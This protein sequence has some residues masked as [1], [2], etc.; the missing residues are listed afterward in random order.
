MP[1]TTASFQFICGDDDFLVTRRGREVF[2]ALAGACDDAFGP[3]II[4]GS[5]GNVSEV[6]A[7]VNQFRASAETLPLFGGAKIIW[8]RGFNAL[9]DSVTGRSDAAKVQVERLQACLEPIDPESVSVVITAF[10]VDRR[11]KEFKWFQKNGQVIDLK[12]RDALESVAPELDRLARDAG[13]TFEPGVQEDLVGQVG[14]NARLAVAETEKLIT[15]LGEGGGTIE[16]Q[17]LVEL[18]PSFGEGDFFETAEAF[19]AAD[20]SWTL[21]ALRRH[22]FVQKDARGLIST[23]Q[24]R[25]RILIQLQALIDSGELKLG[26]RG[27]GKGA[28]EDAGQRWTH[29][30]GDDPPKSS[31]NVFSQNAWYVGNRLAPALRHFN[32]RGLLKIE[33]ALFQVFRD[34]HDRPD[35]QEGVLREM[36]CRCLGAQ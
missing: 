32:L 12:S 1:A 9:A 10:P 5:A 6:E 18:V 28:L 4:E 34:I 8:L 30:F 33:A 26:T 27:L 25:V 14:G 7:M 2:D 16:R 36:A 24:N 11:R 15:Y 31:F 19:F 3:E 20:L 23:M 13:V 35:D 22:F 29:A 17:M 21:D